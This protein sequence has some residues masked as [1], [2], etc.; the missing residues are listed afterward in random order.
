MTHCCVRAGAYEAGI[1]LLPDKLDN[2]HGSATGQQQSMTQTTLGCMTL[3]NQ[4]LTSLLRIAAL[5][6]VL[7]VAALF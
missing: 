6:S 7:K 5:V 1:G 2:L 3:Y 4:G